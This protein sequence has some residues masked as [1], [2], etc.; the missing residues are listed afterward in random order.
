[1]VT[2]K[3]SPP[4]PRC[5]IIGKMEAFEPATE[6]QAPWVTHGQGKEGL[7]FQ[8]VYVHVACISPFITNGDFFRKKS[9]SL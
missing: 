7:R 9:V 5:V 4:S 8:P 1:M 2:S 6:D 3:G